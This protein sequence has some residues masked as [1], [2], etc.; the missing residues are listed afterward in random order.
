MAFN[1]IGELRQELVKEGIKWTVNPALSDN[2]SISRPSLGGGDFSRWTRAETLPRVDVAT[3]IKNTPTSNVLLQAH[4]IDRGFLQ[5]STQAFGGTYANK[6]YKF[7][8][9]GVPAI[10][11]VDWRNGPGDW[12]YITSIRDQAQCEHCWIYAATALIESMVR[13]EHCVWCVRSEGDYIESNKVPC[14]QCGDPRTVLTWVQGNGMTDLDCVPWVDADPGDRSGP[15]WNPSPSGCGTGSM[16]PP[17]TYVPCRNRNGR[18]VKIPAY[19][20]LGNI[21]DQKNWIDSIGPLVVAFDVYSDFQY[22]TGPA[23]YTKVSTATYLGGH[24]MLAVG[25]DDNLNCWI[26]KNSWGTGW[27]ESGFWLIGYGQCNIDSYSKLG[28]RYANPD[29]W[30]KRRSHSGG[31]IESGD[32]T[33]N[34]NFELLAPSKGNSFTHW[35]RDNSASGYPWH[36]AEVLANDVAD[37]P[38]LTATTYNRNFETIYRTTNG[39]LHHYYFDQST[40]KWNDGGIFGPTNVIDGVGYIESNYGPGNFEVVVTV[41]GGNLQHWWRDG[42]GWHQGPTFGSGIV[43][44]G[45]TLIQSIWGNLELVAVLCNGQMQHWWRDGNTWKSDQNFGSGVNSP[46]CMIQ[47]QFGMTNEKGNGNFE[48]CVAMPDGTIQHWWRDNNNKAYPWTM[49]TSFGQNVSRV[50]ALIEGSFGFNLEL[51]ALRNDGML[52][53]Y[54]RDGN[55]WHEGVVIGSIFC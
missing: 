11:R 27:G 24:I 47:G 22:W 20:E 5:P 50:L 4:H 15:Y 54:W 28:L 53:H 6:S 36:S 52:Q 2:I 51:I 10:N 3:L 48:L 29:P 42:N 45:A 38:T 32:G 37:L 40:K 23:P 30:T 44:A 41:A 31:M 9:S 33:L 39:R 7:S 35:W 18:T 25:Y 43:T 1:N 26:V 12:N 16:L 17:P 14:G 19:T 13:I 8:G 49:S 46:P 21:S 55:G 34:D